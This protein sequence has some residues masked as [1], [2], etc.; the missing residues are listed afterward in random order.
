M[1]F[2]V[3]IRQKTKNFTYQRYLGVKP[4]HYF[5]NNEKV[6]FGSD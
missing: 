4:L 3:V 2:S 6:Y 1:R 5:V